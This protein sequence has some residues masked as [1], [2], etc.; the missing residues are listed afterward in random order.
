MKI[1]VIILMVLA[2]VAMLIPMSGVLADTLHPIWSATA[3]ETTVEPI[4]VAVT[5]VSAGTWTPSA[6]GGS[7]TV[8]VASGDSATLTAVLTNI[9]SN[10]DYTVTTASTPS[11]VIQTG[12]TGTWS[13]PTIVVTRNNTATLTFT[14]NASTAAIAGSGASTFTLG[15]SRNE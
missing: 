3:T 9:T 11:G 13:A 4:T 15:L 6:G 10:T 8:N 7:W 14:V 1:K 12:V 5:A 2:I